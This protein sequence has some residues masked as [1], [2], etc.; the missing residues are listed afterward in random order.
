MWVIPW[1]PIFLPLL[2]ISVLSF[3]P[4]L[5]RLSSPNFRYFSKGSIVYV[6]VDLLC[7]WEEMNFGSSYATTLKLLQKPHIVYLSFPYS[8]VH[9]QPSP[10]KP[11]IYFLSLWLS[12]LL[13]F[14]VNEII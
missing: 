7:Q 3:Y 9:H 1:E 6:V 4:L 12:L 8:L 2:C 13:V 10:E 5:W 14:H 11:L